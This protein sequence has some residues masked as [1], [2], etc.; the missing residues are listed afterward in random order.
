[1]IWLKFKHTKT[2]FLIS[3]YGKI[4]VAWKKLGEKKVL[5]KI[6]KNLLVSKEGEK[7]KIEPVK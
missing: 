2:V 3:P 1:M 6:L 4:E 5:L 7:L